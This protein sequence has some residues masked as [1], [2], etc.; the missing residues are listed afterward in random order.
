MR[1]PKN[2]PLPNGAE[3]YTG[4]LTYYSPGLGA[5]GIDS[6]DNDAIVAI[7]HY[8]FDA[9]QTGSDPN[10]NP[11]CNRKIRARRTN[12]KTGQA[13]SIDLTVVDRCMSNIT[14]MNCCTALLTC[15]RH[16]MS[17]HRP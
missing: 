11:L 15:Y 1:R 16:W 13:V 10:K 17:A 7:S 8:T 12:E 2:L 4:D 5:C 6:T 3:V 9:V 14:E